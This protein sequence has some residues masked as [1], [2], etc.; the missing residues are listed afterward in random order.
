MSLLNKNLRR[1]FVLLPGAAVLA[2][3]NTVVLNPSG[4]VAAQQG[5]LVV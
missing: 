3:C 4:D 5:W 1:P 2:G